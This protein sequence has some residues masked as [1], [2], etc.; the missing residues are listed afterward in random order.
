[1]NKQIFLIKLF[2]PVAFTGFYDSRASFMGNYN[3]AANQYYLFVDMYHANAIKVA[4]GSSVWDVEG[5]LCE[6][7]RD[8]LQASI[9][10]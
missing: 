8:D 2:F 7:H 1:V 4:I 5:S 6:I 9:L 3:F 10:W